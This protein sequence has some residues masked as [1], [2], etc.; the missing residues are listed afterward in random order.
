MDREFHFSFKLSDVFKLL[1]ASPVVVMFVYFLFTL[2]WDHANAPGW[3]Q[4][5]GAIISI[6]GAAF[7]P[8][9]HLQKAEERRQASARAALGVVMRKTYDKLWLLTNCFAHPIR[10]KYWMAEYLRN[11]CNTA[12]NE[13]S[14]SI[15]HVPMGELPPNEVVSLGYL[16]DS[17][18]FALQVVS[19][20]PEWVANEYSHPDVVRSLRAKRDILGLALNRYYADPLQCDIPQHIQYGSKLEL[21]MIEAEPVL[22]REVWIYRRFCIR[23]D[24]VAA[25][26]PPYAVVIQAVAPFGKPHSVCIHRD[27]EGWSSMSELNERI[28]SISDE[29]IDSWDYDPR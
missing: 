28:L 12:F 1:M 16:R 15:D 11:H 13:L 8:V 18:A 25:G 17:V 19:M 9:W 23:E 3:V 29:M 22:H 27:K 14:A 4:A 24:E 21:Q 5:V 6:W 10:E 26:V 20:M 7:F 2:P